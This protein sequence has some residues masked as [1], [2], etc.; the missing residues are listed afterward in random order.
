[1]QGD[2]FEKLPK[3]VQAVIATAR[4][5]QKVCKFLR[6]KET[7]ET[8]VNFFFEPSGKRIG[9]AT[10]ARAVASGLLVP[11]HDGLFDGTDQTWTAA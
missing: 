1:M 6:Q 11:S 4:A 10:A 3:R 5:G 2:T 9:P 7:G 8:E